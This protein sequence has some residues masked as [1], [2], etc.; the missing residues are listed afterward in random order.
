MT[1]IAERDLLCVLMDNVPD[2]VY[3]K[4]LQS[5]FIR[6]SRSLSPTFRPVRSGR[7]RRQKRFR[8]LRRRTRPASLPRRAG[9][10]PHWKAVGG[11]KK[12]NIGRMAE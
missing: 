12:W 7:G 3:F 5:R 9:S 1:L 2:A 4:D 8:F 10:D 11:G 6:I